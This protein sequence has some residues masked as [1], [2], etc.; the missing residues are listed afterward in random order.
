MQKHN[1]AITTSGHSS[2]EKYLSLYW[3]VCVWEVSWRLNKDCNILTPLSSSGHSSMSFSFSWAA[4]PGAW[5]L[6]LSAESWFPPLGLEHWTPTAWLPVSPRVISLF[7][8]HSIQPID[9]Q[10]HPPISST[11]CTC[12]LHR[13]ISSFDCLAGS[14][15]NMQQYSFIGITPMSAVTRSGSASS[16][17]IYGSNRLV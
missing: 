3:K 13:C 16:G 12:Y 4:Q 7:Y 8:T 2:V 11:G 9:S 6:T 10:G 14:E 1:D 5:G 15:V 17:P